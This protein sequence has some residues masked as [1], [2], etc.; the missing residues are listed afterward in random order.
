MNLSYFY[1]LST[2]NICFFLLNVSILEYIN[3]T[4]CK[5][6]KF[7]NS[8]IKYFHIFKITKLIFLLQC[9]PAFVFCFLFAIKTFHNDLTQTIHLIVSA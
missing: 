5:R 3:R 6:Y 7:I 4:Q 2:S 8:G 1:L 9:F